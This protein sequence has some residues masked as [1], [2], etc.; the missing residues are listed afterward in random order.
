MNQDGLK[1]LDSNNTKLVGRPKARDKRTSKFCRGCMD[2][3]GKFVSM[4][5]MCY[6][7]T[8]Q[9]WLLE[10]EFFDNCTTYATESVNVI[11]QC[12]CIP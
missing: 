3:D 10:N 1:S 4:C 7:H 6:A 8:H 9:P 12:T 11:Q 2:S 5:E